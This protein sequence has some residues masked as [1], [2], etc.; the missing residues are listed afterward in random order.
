ML[1]LTIPLGIALAAALAVVVIVWRK[2]PYLRKL[3]PESHEVG[4][5]MLHDMAP[6]L[7]DWWRGIPWQQYEHTV[8][9]EAE[10]VLHWMRTLVGSVD[11]ASERLAKGVRRAG[12]E[13]AKSHEVAVA[14]REEEKRERELEQEPPDEVDLTDPEQLKAEEQRLIVAIAQDPKDAALYS[15][16]ARVYMRSHAYGDA[17]EALE[18]AHKLV[19]ENESYL[20][21]LGRAKQ[22][23][24]ETR[25][26]TP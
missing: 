25:S 1:Y 2:M 26:D 17:V 18:Q 21:R 8:L 20:K 13:A 3:T 10:Q 22:K 16:I 12:Q 9:M 5:T 15:D 6:E 19:P 24:T 4:Q 23:F 14:Q 11:R 7:V